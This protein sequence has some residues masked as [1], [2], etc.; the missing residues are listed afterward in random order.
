VTNAIKFTPP[1]GSITC[2]SELGA[3]RVLVRVRDT[4]S[5]IPR[6]QLGAI[7]EPFV[8]VPRDDARPDLRGVGLGLAISRALA[9][10]MDGDLTVESATGVGSTFTLSLPAA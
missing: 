1:G 8:Q 10:G 5:G 6:D 4:G 7:F 2:W 9:R 3:G